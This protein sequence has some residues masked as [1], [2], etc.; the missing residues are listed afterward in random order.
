MENFSLSMWSVI[1]WL[2]LATSYWEGQI[3]NI[4]LG[5]FS[6]DILLGYKKLKNDITQITKLNCTIIFC[7]RG[8]LYLLENPP[9]YT[10]C[11]FLASNTYDHLRSIFKLL[12]T[13]VYMVWLSVTSCCSQ[14]C[15]DA[16]HCQDSMT[17]I[18]TIAPD[19]YLWKF[20][21]HTFI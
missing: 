8:C 2:T 12:K 5:D 13:L 14:V 4:M 18:S 11:N 19:L 21:W 1:K 16:T 9:V 3:W 15:Y 20:Q 6:G 7:F 17:W 10:R